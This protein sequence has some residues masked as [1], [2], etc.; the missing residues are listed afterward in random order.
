[1]KFPKIIR[2]RKAE[3]T[4]YGKKESYPFYRLSWRFNGRR[5]MQSFRTYR[6]AKAAG[7]K[8]V[9][10]LAKG[11]QSLA[12]TAKE[13]TG[14]LAITPTTKGWRRKRRQ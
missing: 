11:S 10:E 1:V 8:K 3:V 2:H 9:R 14:A 5:H 7:D 4:I 13:V 6:E 12:L